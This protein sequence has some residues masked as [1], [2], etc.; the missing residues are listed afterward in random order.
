MKSKRSLSEC[1]VEKYLLQISFKSIRKR[2]QP[3]TFLAWSL[4]LFRKK[5]FFP[6][7]TTKTPLNI[8]KLVTRV[9][10]F[11]NKGQT[12]LLL[13]K[14]CLG[15]FNFQRSLTVGL[16][17]MSSQFTSKQKWMYFP[18]MLTTRPLKV[19]V[20]VCVLLRSLSLECDLRISCPR[21]SCKSSRV[22]C[23]QQSAVGYKVSGELY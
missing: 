19:N 16:L 1:S 15:Q 21:T 13:L 2:W 3:L 5:N 12:L 9:S 14:Y 22:L 6:S 4:K 11:R 17:P 7:E 10:T 23:P 20:C 8:S 18:H